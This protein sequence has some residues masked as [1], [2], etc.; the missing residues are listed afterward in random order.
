[1]PVDKK[2]E[3][4]SNVSGSG[5]AVRDNTRTRFTDDIGYL[6]ASSASFKERDVDITENPLG[7]MPI[8]G[9]VLQAGQA[10]RDAMDK[11]YGRALLNAGL[12]LVPNMAERPVKELIN[13]VETLL[14][15]PTSSSRLLRRADDFF[16]YSG[17]NFLT[18]GIPS[19]YMEPITKGEDRL[20]ITP[21]FA[22]TR[23]MDHNLVIDNPMRYNDYVFIADK[24]LLDDSVIYKGDGMTPTLGSPKYTSKYGWGSIPSSD[25]ESVSEDLWQETLHGPH[26]GTGPK[27]SV[28]DLSYMDTPLSDRY[29]EAVI[30]GPVPVNR[31]KFGLYPVP[32]SRDAEKV[33]RALDDTGIPYMLY[34]KKYV[35]PYGS[36]VKIPYAGYNIYENGLLDAMTG[37]AKDLA[38][39]SGGSI[40]IKPSHRGRLTELKARTG[41]TEAE[42]YNDGNPAHKKMVVFARNARKWSHADGGFLHEYP[43]GGRIR[44]KQN[45]RFFVTELSPRR[46]KKFQDWYAGVA[47]VLGLDPN[48]DTYEH[49]YDYRGYWLN[50]RDADVSSPDFHFPDTWKQ[51]HHPTFSNESIYAKGREGVGHWEGDTFVPGPFNNLMQATEPSAQ[52]ATPVVSSNYSPSEGILNYIKD[53]EQYRGDW[54]QDGNGVW[55]VG[56]GFTGDDVRK[57]FPNG[58]TRDE[59]DR[60]FADTV[61]RRV[62]MFISATPN[63]DKLNQ[64][65]RDALFSYYYNIGHGGYTRKSPAMQKALEAMDLDTVVKNIDFGYNDSKNRGLR[66]RR[67]YERSLFGTPMDYGG[68]M[69][70]LRKVYGD[71]ESIKAAILRAKNKKK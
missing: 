18:H 6:P 28:D 10:V 26:R 7:Y 52:T 47:P 57:R 66:K 70:R 16:P 19:E 9:D 21:S 22:V 4:A 50:N 14:R 67:D 55:T 71:N 2:K 69:D 65:Q 62:P 1:M 46:E 13:G 37:P 36:G 15:R 60:Y 29:F 17:R 39:A 33:V 38:F 61:S 11:R 23:P 8:I 32:E 68:Y 25:I 34:D 40:H 59:A 27:I 3:L 41:K 48:P 45:G 5:F 20:F 63:F 49:A 53:I 44:G 35:P 58:M 64:N 12:L 42:L 24:S 30:H 54:Y 43:D 31:M 56:Y 51:P